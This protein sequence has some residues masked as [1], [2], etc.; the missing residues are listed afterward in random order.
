MTTIKLG[1]GAWV[2]V[3]AR[4]EQTAGQCGAV[5]GGAE[6]GIAGP[7]LHRHNTFTELYVLLEGRLELTR[8][9]ELLDLG[10]GDV[11]V[12][13]AGVPHA[14]KVCGDT[15][16]RWVNIWT[17]G[18]FEGYFEEAAAALPTDA[19]PDPKVLAEIASRYGLQPVEDER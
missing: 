18:G 12:V 19:P 8:G 17:P 14:F 2:T 9:N 15:Q 13:P 16:A 5:L 3:V 1:A 10:P 7:P 6:P 4:A 11:A